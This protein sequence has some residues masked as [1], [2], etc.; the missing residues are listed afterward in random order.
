MSRA[1][2]TKRRTIEPDVIYRSRLVAK[3]INRSMKEGKK[4]AAQ[5]EVYGALELVG[6]KTGKEA[7]VVFDQ[8]LENIKPDVE[9]RSRRVGGAAYQ[10]PMPVRGERR[11]TLAVR[12]L[13]EAARGRS[14]KECRHFAEKLAAEIMDALS[15]QGMAIRKREGV[16]KMAETNRAF[17]HFRW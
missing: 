9:V 12:W 14:N 7:I 10:V 13:V 3:L 6:K 17:A 16:H 1:G 5:R 4:T 11:E 2:K 15:N 8:A